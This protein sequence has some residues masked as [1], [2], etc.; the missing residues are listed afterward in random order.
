[1]LY[2]AALLLFVVSVLP[3]VLYVTDEVVFG[4]S[5][6]VKQFICDID[7][8]LE[9]AVAYN[10]KSLASKMDVASL[11]SCVLEPT[12]IFNLLTPC[13]CVTITKILLEA[14]L[15]VIDAVRFVSVNEVLAIETSV[16]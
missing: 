11:R 2:C 15:G 6:I 12:A 8:S 14:A 13:G 7:V 10:E 5:K 16:G 4:E 1:L 9:V 3:W